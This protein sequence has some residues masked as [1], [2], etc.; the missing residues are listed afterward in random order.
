MKMSGQEDTPVV[1]ASPS[2]PSSPSEPK[3]RGMFDPRWTPPTVIYCQGHCKNNELLEIQNRLNDI[4]ERLT[5]LEDCTC[6]LL[7]PR[8]L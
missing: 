8:L 6:P 4:G 2:S 5:R 7:L 3:P 1:T